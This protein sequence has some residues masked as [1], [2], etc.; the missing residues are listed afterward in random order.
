MKFKR[1]RPKEPKEISKV[2][3]ENVHIFQT[4][5]PEVSVTVTYKCDNPRCNSPAEI[6]YNLKYCKP[7]AKDRN[8]DAS[9]GG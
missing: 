1:G 3:P 2:N 5:L 9:S 4:T 7:C 6:F 8:L